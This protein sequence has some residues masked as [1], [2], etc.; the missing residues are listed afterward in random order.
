MPLPE[1]A[2]KHFAGKVT[3]QVQ[4][5]TYMHLFYKKNI[6]KSGISYLYHFFQQVHKFLDKN[7]DQ[8]RQEVL[9]LFMQ[10]KNKVTLYNVTEHLLWV[11]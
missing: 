9:D 8:V 4:S 5:I 11:R 7:Y 3:Y 6:W 1:F 2:I 10:S